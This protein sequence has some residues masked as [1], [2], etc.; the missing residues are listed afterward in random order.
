MMI[1]SAIC[2]INKVFRVVHKIWSSSVGDMDK[3]FLFYSYINY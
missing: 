2:I 3:S 1:Q